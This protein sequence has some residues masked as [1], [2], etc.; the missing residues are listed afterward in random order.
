MLRAAILVVVLAV[1]A[2]AASC[3]ADDPPVHRAERLQPAYRALLEDVAE[4]RGLPA[5]E[6]LRLGAVPRATTGEL[7]ASVASS[8]NARDERWT[9]MLRL[10][11]L[12]DREATYAD[13]WREAAASSAAAFYLPGRRE[14]W[15]VL[16]GPLPADPNELPPWQRRMLVHEM[17]HALQDCAFDVAALERRADSFDAWLSL[18]AL[19]EGDAVRTESQWTSERLLPVLGSPSDLDPPAAATLQPFLVR[20]A[21]FTYDSGHAYAALVEREAY[22]AVNR[23]LEA[24]GPGSTAIVLRP[25]L[26]ATGWQRGGASLPAGA[27]MPEW[28][29]IGDDRLG[30][31]LLASYLQSGL[32]AL[33]AVQAAAGWTDDA[34]RVYRTPA[35]DFAMAVR[36]TFRDAKEAGEFASAHRS[37]L[38]NQARDLREEPGLIVTERQDGVSVVQI[39][40]QGAS[41]TL[42]LAERAEDALALAAYLRNR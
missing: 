41:V 9:A 11:G 1:G 19:L 3:R 16:D 5:P 24:G 32:P 8:N 27:P 30:E 33:A 25:D 36:V 31:F 40:A 34:A 35:G 29:P 7:L 17:V 12:L 28:R 20:E 37:M 13:A 2:L 21:R 14:I 39:E 10:L 42:V 38:A 15:L 4:M 26:V 22:G 23:L 18:R 6:S